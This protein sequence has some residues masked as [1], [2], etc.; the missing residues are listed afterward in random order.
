MFDRV[1]STSLRSRSFINLF[2]CQSHKTFKHSNNASAILIT[3]CELRYKNRERLVLK[4]RRIQQKTGEYLVFSLSRAQ[5]WYRYI[6]KNTFLQNTSGAC[7]WTEK[8]NPCRREYGKHW[9]KMPKS[10]WDIK[11]MLINLKD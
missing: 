10:K 9:R 11:V 3:G 6:A 2:K 8:V 7:F 1:G 4:N 5:S